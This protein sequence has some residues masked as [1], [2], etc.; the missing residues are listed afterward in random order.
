VSSQVEI[1]Q[2]LK[3]QNDVVLSCHNL[4]FNMT[5]MLNCLTLLK[6]TTQILLACF[7][8]QKT[9]ESENAVSAV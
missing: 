6:Q 4:W 5:L 2:V 3:Q 7:L 8:G 9:T 1:F